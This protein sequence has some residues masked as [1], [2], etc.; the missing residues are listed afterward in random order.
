VGT[1]LRS[2]LSS[3][4][5]LVARTRRGAQDAAEELVRR[6][7][8]QAWRAALLMTGDRG[9]AEDLVQDAFERALRKLDT[10]DGR[11]AFAPWLHRILTNR[12]LDMRPRGPGHLGLD[13]RLLSARDQYVVAD[14]TA[15]LIA[16]LRGLGPERRAVVV[17]RLLFGYSPPEIAELLEVEVGTVHSR[18]SRGLAELRQVLMVS[19]EA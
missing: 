13:E 18:L 12:A 5:D 3:D 10:F 6:H 16:A 19:D 15:E 2:S 7:W 1:T 8:P 11:R 4:A 14:D 17:L 9:L